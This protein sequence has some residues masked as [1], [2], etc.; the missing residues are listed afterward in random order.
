MSHEKPLP[1]ISDDNAAFWQATKEHELRLQRCA[2]C[3]HFRYPISKV[4]PECLS[5]EAEWTRVSGRGTVYACVTFHQVYH[6]AYAG[7][8]PYNVSMI[9]LDEGPRMISNVVGCPVDQVRVG[10]AVEVRFDDVNDTI[11]IPR[12]S[13]A[14]NPT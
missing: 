2:A 5:E 8:T 14:G 12:F 9:Q 3:H 1:I 6:P 7:E 4:C 10:D 13:K 11:T